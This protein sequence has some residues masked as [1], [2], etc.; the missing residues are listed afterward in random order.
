M[1]NRDG[2][3]SFTVNVAKKPTQKRP[4]PFPTANVT[5]KNKKRLTMILIVL[6]KEMEMQKRLLL[7][8]KE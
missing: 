8:K 5:Q 4:A 1:Q 7:Q 6:P 2:F 3:G